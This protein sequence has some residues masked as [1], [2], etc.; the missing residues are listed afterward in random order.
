MVLTFP[1]G[2]DIRKRAKEAAM[3][4]LARALGCTDVSVEA[5]GDPADALFGPDANG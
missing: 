5:D 4:T 1:V 2:G 3:R